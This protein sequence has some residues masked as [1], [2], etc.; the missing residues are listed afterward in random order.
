MAGGELYGLPSLAIAQTITISNSACIL[1]PKLAH[2][3]RGNSQM[4]SQSRISS[5]VRH[6][7]T[8]RTSDDHFLD[9]ETAKK[10]CPP[11]CG[12]VSEL[13][14]RS[15]SQCV[16]LLR[17]HPHINHAIVHLFACPSPSSAIAC[18]LF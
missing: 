17:Q 1:L 13:R 7:V 18:A 15:V 12:P 3:R 2:I 11:K 8:V 9:I 4:T 10:M 14:D 16:S 6:D 5:Y